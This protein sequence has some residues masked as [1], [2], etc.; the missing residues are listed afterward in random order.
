MYVFRK[1]KKKKKL[2]KF[3]G[4][5]EVC[6]FSRFT[7]PCCPWEMNVSLQHFLTSHL[8]VSPAQIRFLMKQK[9]FKSSYLPVRSADCSGYS[10]VKTKFINCSWNIICSKANSFHLYS[11]QQ[12]FCETL[13]SLFSSFL[14]IS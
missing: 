11:L 3:L 1:I 9:P 10:D 2:S 5:F 6:N 8:S 14:F 12:T 13:T 4:L 7:C